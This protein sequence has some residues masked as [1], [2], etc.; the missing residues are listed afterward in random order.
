MVQLSD[1]D[2]EL[3]F[4]TDEQYQKVVGIEE[5]ANLKSKDSVTIFLEVSTFVHLEIGMKAKYRLNPDGK[6]YSGQ[7]DLIDRTH[8][9]CRFMYDFNNL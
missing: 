6:T 4:E 1:L 9:A 2:C 5:T 7:L 3:N 8:K